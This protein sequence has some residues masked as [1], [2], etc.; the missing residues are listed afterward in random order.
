MCRS[1]KTLR[2][3]EIPA[4]EEESAAKKRKKKRLP[5]N[6]GIL[7]DGQQQQC[8]IDPFNEMEEDPSK[9]GAL[10]AFSASIEQN[11]RNLYIS[12]KGCGL[13]ALSYGDSDPYPTP[14]YST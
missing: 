13:T 4:T 2:N 10:D 12:C 3:T 14:S 11:M 6:Q 9:T 5:D 7:G 1:I 8:G